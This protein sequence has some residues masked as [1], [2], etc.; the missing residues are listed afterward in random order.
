M[1]SDNEKLRIKNKI[2]ASLKVLNDND[3]ILLENSVNE[4]TI[5]SKFAMYLQSQFDLTVD[6]EYNKHGEN[7][8]KV[9]MDIKECSKKKKSDY[10]IPDIIVHERKNDEHNILVIEMKKKRKDNCDIKKLEKFTEQSGIFGYKL[11]LFI[12]FDS[13]NKPKLMWFENGREIDL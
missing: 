10:V 11:G 8:R 5:S 2:E 7:A 12:R 13:S 9:L 1:L 4:R 3:S 6:H